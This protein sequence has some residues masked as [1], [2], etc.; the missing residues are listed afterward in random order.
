MKPES[1]QPIRWEHRSWRHLSIFLILGKGRPF[2]GGLFPNRT[3]NGATAGK[4]SNM[5]I[6]NLTGP[7]KEVTQLYP[8]LRREFPNATI[9]WRAEGHKTPVPLIGSPE[10]CGA[11]ESDEPYMPVVITED[12][13]TNSI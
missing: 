9:T 3:T 1:E 6:I 4:D 8:S 11:D 10:N 7:L 2:A 13:P 5:L 12:E